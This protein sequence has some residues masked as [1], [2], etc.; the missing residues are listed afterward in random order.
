MPHFY[1]AEEIINEEVI[2]PDL[3]DLDEV[4]KAIIAKEILD[5]KY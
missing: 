4:R 1:M 5:R 3:S 2:V